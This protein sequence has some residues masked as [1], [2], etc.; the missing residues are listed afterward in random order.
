MA[1]SRAVR[2]TFNEGN[3]R[4]TRVVLFIAVALLLVN[5][6]PARGEDHRSDGGISILDETHKKDDTPDHI[7]LVQWVPTES[8]RSSLERDPRN[9]HETIQDEVQMFDRYTVFIVIDA[10]KGGRAV[11]DYTPSELIRS[12]ATMVSPQGETFAPL[13]EDA[14]VWRAKILLPMLKPIFTHLFGSLGQHME[15]LFFPGKDKSGTKIVD[16]RAC[17]NLAWF[18]RSH[19]PLWEHTSRSLRLDPCSF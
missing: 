19:H 14:L 5:V 11:L 9:A 18:S 7:C 4:V 2:S 12:T 13:K 17:A 3:L 1:E 10:K 15:F 16:P 8:W 6:F